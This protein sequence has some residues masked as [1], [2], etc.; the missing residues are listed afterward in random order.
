[1]TRLRK[2][3][4]WSLPVMAAVVALMAPAAT[5]FAHDDE[6]RFVCAVRLSV[7]DPGIDDL[8]GKKI[9]NTGAVATGVVDCATSP[10]D[11]GVLGDHPLDSIMVTDHG[12]KVKAKRDPLS[13]FPFP[14]RGKLDGTFTLYTL[15]MSA[16]I[17]TGELEG[18]VKGVGVWFPGYASPVY[19]GAA[20]IPLHETIKGK[21][22]FEGSG[23]EAK[24]KFKF[25]LLV[26]D[27]GDF[28]FGALGGSIFGEMESDSI[29]PDG[30]DDDNG[31][32]DDDNGDDD[33]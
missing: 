14:F 10:A 26:G 27:P 13:G 32:D 24:A 19:P 4:L 31:D 25:R 3:G 2:L 20:L 21:L 30:D 29:E 11:L 18:K 7:A 22:E 23:L 12:S 17:G 16:V 33:D 15:D 28:G 8:D 6:E 9:T 1:M 5:V